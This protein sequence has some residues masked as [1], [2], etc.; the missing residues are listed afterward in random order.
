MCFKFAPAEEEQDARAHCP[1]CWKS[2]RT[3]IHIP[4]KGVS[5]IGSVPLTT[6]ETDECARVLHLLKT[7]SDTSTDCG[8]FNWILYMLLKDI[9]YIT[10]LP[11]F[12]ILCQSW[13]PVLLYF[14]K[15]NNMSHIFGSP[16]ISRKY[17]SYKWFINIQSI[18]THWVSIMGT[19]LYI[20][21]YYR[22]SE[23]FEHQNILQKCTKFLNTQFTI[24]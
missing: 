22:I 3:S 10:V 15:R 12:L 2:T 17:L 4:W 18:N 16:S 9:S 19:I 14:E 24:N 6:Q 7:A 20:R 5:P 8:T 11:A 1:P 13:L 21:I 23:Y